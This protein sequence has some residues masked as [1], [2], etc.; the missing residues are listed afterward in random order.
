MSITFTDKEGN[1]IKCWPGVEYAEHGIPNVGDHVLLHW[2]DYN[3]DI[4]EYVVLW[5]TFD[6][7]RPDVVYCTI[8][9][10]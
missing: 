6:G 4:E 9:R 3:E 5:R 1:F 7:V 10:V 2:G 8:E